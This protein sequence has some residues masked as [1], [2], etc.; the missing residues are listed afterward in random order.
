MEGNT[1]R[2]GRRS[3]KRTLREQLRLGVELEA[4]STAKYTEVWQ[5]EARSTVPFAFAIS[6]A[7]GRERRD[8]YAPGRESEVRVR[9]GEAS[10]GV[11]Q[12]RGVAI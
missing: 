7:P 9:N 11:G 8:E 6:I 10:Q 5:D 1:R 3:N 2:S 4:T 12:H